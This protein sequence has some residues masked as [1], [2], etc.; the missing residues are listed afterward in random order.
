M[1]VCSEAVGTAPMEIVLRLKIQGRRV[2]GEWLCC[3]YDTLPAEK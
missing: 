1:A 2:P 3:L